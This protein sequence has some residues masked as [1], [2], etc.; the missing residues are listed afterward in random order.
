MVVRIFYRCN[1][2]RDSKPYMLSN[3]RSNGISYIQM[4]RIKKTML[5]NVYLA[6]HWKIKDLTTTIIIRQK[7]TKE[8]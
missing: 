5:K 4:W 3:I 1:P 2:N 7:E 6:K 8:K